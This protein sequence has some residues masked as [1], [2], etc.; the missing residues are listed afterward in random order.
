MPIVE[1]LPPEIWDAICEF[2]GQASAHATL[3]TCRAIYW[4]LSPRA[5][6]KIVLAPNPEWLD[7]GVRPDNEDWSF[8]RNIGH[9]C[10]GFLRTRRLLTAIDRDCEN[11]DSLLEGRWR[12][13][14]A[15]RELTICEFMEPPELEVLFHVLPHVRKTNIYMGNFLHWYRQ[16]IGGE[17]AGCRSLITIY[18]D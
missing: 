9:V 15:C 17:E 11:P 8:H 12:H 14:S 7:I 1:A 18:I 3:R 6:R 2:M 5:W 4:A 10:R 16:A 13:L